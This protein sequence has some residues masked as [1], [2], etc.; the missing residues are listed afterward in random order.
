M[1]RYLQFA[2]WRKFS[3]LLYVLF[4]FSTTYG[5][6]STSKVKWELQARIGASHIRVIDRSFSQLTYQTTTI[7]GGVSLRVETRKIFHL[8]QA[9]ASAGDL[10]NDDANNTRADEFFVTGSYHLGYIL[11]KKAVRAMAGIGLGASYTE[12]EYRGFI[13]RSISSERIFWGGLSAGLRYRKS[14][15]AS[16]IFEE[17]LTVPLL[18]Y[19]RQPAFGAESNS[20][21]M[22][23]KWAS[24]SLLF[25]LT[26][27]V[28]VSRV[29]A[30]RH[31]LSLAY[32]WDYYSIQLDREV[33]HVNHRLTL[34]YQ[35]RF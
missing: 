6:D 24:P 11:G 15:D 7:T 8:L 5:Q 27:A 18:S 4:L 34:G 31:A 17:I 9:D 35:Y 13:N 22:V 3:T 19:V 12:R 29:L 28:S 30:K 10:T 16:W 14:R 2:L 26:N 25:R 33:R 21:P 20:G 23:D 1:Y 32:H